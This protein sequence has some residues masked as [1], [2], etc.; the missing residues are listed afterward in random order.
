LP[1][2]GAAH[3]LALGQDGGYFVNFVPSHGGVQ[4]LKR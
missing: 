1:G 4:L 3:V 2:R